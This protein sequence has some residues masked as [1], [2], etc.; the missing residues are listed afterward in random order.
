[1]PRVLVLCFDTL[2]LCSATERTILPQGNV[3]SEL[4]QVD[5]DGMQPNFRKENDRV[6]ASLE[7]ACIG[8]VLS[9]G[10]STVSHSY[11]VTQSTGISACSSA[12]LGLI[13]LSYH[14][15]DS[16]CE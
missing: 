12:A 10:G 2:C 7:K 6:R 16:F 5:K 11:L 15:K 8:I 1:M 4:C 9:D 14:F 3:A 13:W